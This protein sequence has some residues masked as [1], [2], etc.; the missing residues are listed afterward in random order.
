MSIDSI[1]NSSLS[2]LFTSQAA[3]GVTSN[4][5]ANVNTEDYS[6]LKIATSALVLQGEAAGVQV[7]KIYRVVD[8]YLNSAYRNA[9]SS[10][11]QYDI[12]ATF[13][14]RIQGQLGSPDSDSS[15]AARM[16]QIYA[17]LADLTLNPSDTLRRQ[18][19]LA[20]I[21]STLQGV[22]QLAETIQTLRGNASQQITDQIEVLNI[23][24]ERVH[25]LNP[26]VAASKLSG[27][28]SGALEGEMDSALAEISKYISIN[29]NYN[30]DGTV[31]V[32]GDT[33]QIL[34]DKSLYKLGYSSPGTS[35]AE[36]DY[37]LIQIY[38]VDR[39]TKE[40]VVPG[41]DYDASISSGSLR[42]LLDLRDVQL[43]DY[44][45]TVGEFGANLRDQFNA[46]HNSLS[47]VPAPNQLVGHQ[48]AL[49][50]T[51][52]PNF[53]GIVNFAITDAN[54]NLVAKHTVD[55]D[56]AP[57]ATYNALIAQVNAGLAGAG[58]LSMVGGVMEF[59]ATNAANGVV[60]SDDAVA[61]S[62]I[63]GRGFSHYFGMNDLITSGQLGY[64]ETGLKGTDTHGMVVP[65][66]AT[67]EVVDVY[68]RSVASV[69]VPATGTNFD[70][71]VGELNNAAGLGAYF[72][73]TLGAD[74]ALSWTENP[75]YP[76]VRLTVVS[77][78]T[79]VNGTNVP[80][81]DLFGM[82]YKYYM[83]A[84][85]DMGIEK[86]ID[87]DLNLLSMSQFDASALVGATAIT[88]GDQSGALRF[89][90]FEI[91]AVNFRAAGELSHANVTLS[92]YLNQVL[93]NSGKM[94]NRAS[95]LS[96]DYTSTKNDLGKRRMDVGGVNL[97]EEMANMVV[98]QNAYSASA[99]MLTSAQELFD[100]LLRAV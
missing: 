94:S 72:T 71:I 12:Q 85:K 64:Y 34:I 30:A 55:F 74:G 50:G 37:P 67:F 8:T 1:I 29:V 38:R 43:R 90:D 86:R 20:D 15:L 70:D 83:D 44:A 77:D 45:L 21:D 42:G 13:H 31:I 82:G 80:L 79:N 24:L 59:T 9:I 66:V 84:A 33:G 32:S 99:R 57:P 58:T 97:D 49:I 93:G 52:V 35:A 39:D 22:S 10:S 98:Y 91:N 3:L 17:S 18:G 19:W 53:T 36:T 40:L 26:L 7:D 46:A 63:A 60:I 87:L 6:R 41:R 75:A 27:N 2:G 92:Q 89:Q 54:N 23:Q 95:S 62:Q 69:A 28:S 61:P 73:F 96:Q 16:N 47:A 25:A 65:Q 56:G 4:N 100:T 11:S 48:T 14:D 5:I 78:S 51:S 68:G 76:G 81:T 88:Y